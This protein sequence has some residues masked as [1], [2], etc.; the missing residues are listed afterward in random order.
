M[1]SVRA[2][3]VF[4]SLVC[5]A[6]FGT[7]LFAAAV[8]VSDP[9]AGAIQ[10]RNLPTIKAPSGGS[11]TV[12]FTD[13]I[14]DS[15][16]GS[17]SCIQWPTVNL[18]DPLENLAA[19]VTRSGCTYTFTMKAN[20]PLATASIT[21]LNFR[22][23][24]NNP[25]SV[26]ISVQPGPDSSITYTAPTGLRVEAGQTIEIN[27]RSYASEADVSYKI[28]CGDATSIDNTRIDSVTRDD[29]TYTVTPKYVLGAAS[30][31][32]PYTSS[33]NGSSSGLISL[34][35]TQPTPPTDFVFNAPTG[36]SV[37]TNQTLTID[38]SDYASDGSNTISCEDA[39]RVNTRQ[40]QSV[41]RGRGVNG[42]KFTITPPHSSVAPSVPYSTSFS[43]PYTSSGGGI[44]IR[45]VSVRVTAPSSIDFTAPA[46]TPAVTVGGSLRLDLGAYASDGRYTVY[47]GAPVIVTGAASLFNQ[48]GCIVYLSAGSSAGTAT[49]EVTYTSS[50]GAN[51]T[52]TVSVEVI[53]ASNI[54]FTPPSGLIVGTNRTLVIDASEYVSETDD[55]YAIA[56]GDATSI[57]TVE[58]QSVTRNGCM[59]TVT[60]KAVQGMA[61][62]V[63]PYTSDGGDTENGTINL[64]VGPPSTILFTDP[65]LYRATTP[66]S[67]MIDASTFVSDNAAYNISCGG[68]AF[69]PREI[70]SVV[71]A[72]PGS[73]SYTVTLTGTP[74]PSSLTINYISTGGHS[75]TARVSLTVAASS[76]T[77]TAPSTAPAATAGG[78]VTIDAGAFARDGRFAIT[79]GTATNSSSSI[80]S[81]SRNGCVYTVTAGASADASASFT[82]PYTSSG[83]ATANGVVPVNIGQ[84]SSVSY[85]ALTDLRV[86]TGATKTFDLS[87][88][89]TDGGYRIS[90]GAASS[91]SP[92]LTSVSNTGCNFA[93]TA[94]STQGTA[95]FTVRF[96]SA[97]GTNADGVVSVNVGAASSLAFRPPSGLILGAGN[98]RVFDLSSY[99]TD[100]NYAVKCG[101]PSS[102]PS[103]RLTVSRGSLKADGGFDAKGCQFTV[104][105]YDTQGATSFSVPVTSEATDTEVT[106]T[107][108]IAIGAASNIVFS[109]LPAAYAPTVP[110]DLP[111][112]PKLDPNDCS[113]FTINITANSIFGGAILADCQALVALQNHWATEA[114]RNLPLNHFL[115]TWGT[116]TERLDR[117]EG[118]QVGTQGSRGLVIGLDLSMQGIRGTLPPGFGSGFGAGEGLRHLR[119]LDLNGNYLTGTMPASLNSFSQVPLELAVPISGE[120]G[121]LQR[122][123]FCNNYFRG[124][125]PTLLSDA[126]AN[127]QRQSFSPSSL[128][129]AGDIP[130]QLQG[131]PPAAKARSSSYTYARVGTGAER[132]V[133]AWITGLGLDSASYDSDPI[134]YWDTDTSQWAD[135]NEF[136]CLTFDF[137]DPANPSCTRVSETSLPA[138][139]VIRWRNGY[140]DTA[141][142]ASL[143]LT[144]VS[145]S[146]T[147]PVN[148]FGARGGTITLDASRYASDGSYAV[149]CSDDYLEDDGIFASVTQTGAGRCTFTLRVKAAADT[150]VEVAE[151]ATSYPFLDVTFISTGGD[152]VDRSFFFFIARSMPEPPT[153][154]TRP[155][156]EQPGP[157]QPGPAPAPE[158]TRTPT[159]EPAETATQSGW[160]TFTAQSSVTPAAIRRQLNLPR[161]QPVYTWDAETQAWTRI[162]NPAQTIPAGT[163]ISFLS[164]GLTTEE[165]QAANLGRN[166][167]QASLTNGWNIINIA[168]EA[169]RADD[170]DFL[171]D[172]ALV[173]CDDLFGVIAVVSYDA[174]TRRW[175]LYLPCHPRAEARLTTGED[176]PYDRMT[177]LSEGD[178][179]YIY[180]RSRIPLEV[181]WNTET[182]TYQPAS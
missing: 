28:F 128:F 87:S 50:G 136:T 172:N 59:F 131:S 44:A 139:S 51:S 68:V 6:L 164:R 125:L 13:Y 5:A 47:C 152:R 159:T 109:G 132:R 62:F 17:I 76:I 169:E 101:N 117:W 57:D 9:A 93:V 85:T 149:T 110:V 161:S 52:Q 92:S 122:F 157:A 143:N 37:A 36:L 1:L 124:A 113:R 112:I 178:S 173:D 41:V 177:S 71:A 162:T 58:I 126:R 83:G 163:S 115:R 144:N 153:Q 14:F 103:S 118:V 107:V 165:I 40:L 18:S 108:N 75:V 79:C 167:P 106:A 35:V 20:P 54:T 22:D 30:F 43:V 3:Q 116:S 148:A 38:A 33:V 105:A 65:D 142:L 182:Q 19:Q 99:A 16:G 140:Y 155:E 120:T 78:T 25:T 60:P 141:T 12:D 179:T 2:V 84:S 102:I 146:T 73:C 69:E 127:I 26:M 49:V 174:R 90:C 91:I 98:T 170:S 48:A 70:T 63:V 24:A 86:A 66:T 39:V 151:Q 72:S 166:T 176:A 129:A 34:Q 7:V 181:T 137:T 147:L 175:S 67:L 74:G 23:S 77:F 29:C 31:T 53:E 119:T 111:P 133:T 114:N 15:A 95:T 32:V 46:A 135:T 156:P 158:P 8:A 145:L 45:I 94:G 56:C 11:N 21:G 80:S 168:G 138:G 82:V 96:T 89:A 88:A 100:G 130:C 171:V 4:A 160:N 64:Q 154:P 123:Y 55:S 121:S 134:E 180:T 10:V 150:T 97:G 27:A 61:S 81:I 104:T 42:C